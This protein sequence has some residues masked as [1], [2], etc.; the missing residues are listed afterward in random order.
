MIQTVASSGQGPMGNGIA[1]TCAAAGLSVVIVD[2]SD[3]A[4]TGAIATVGGSA[5]SGWSRRSK[6]GGGS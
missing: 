2:I 1:Q 5:Q 3:A 4:V 6:I